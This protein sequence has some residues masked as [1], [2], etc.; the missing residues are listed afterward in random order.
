RI[1]ATWGYEPS[2]AAGARTLAYQRTDGQAGAYRSTFTRS[3]DSLTEIPPPI[4]VAP[5]VTG[6][7][8]LPERLSERDLQF[9]RCLIQLAFEA[10]QDGPPSNLTYLEE[11]YYFVP[12]H[13]ALQL[14]SRGQYT[15]ALDWFRMVYDYSAPADQRKIY[16]GLTR[17]ESLPTV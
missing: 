6:P 17:E 2:V 1:V 14:Q 12:A 10:N 11:A 16:Y 3:G 8:E 7:F 13:L 15:A 4:R 5:Y 9:R